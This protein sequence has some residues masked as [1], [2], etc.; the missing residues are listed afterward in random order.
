[1]S[2]EIRRS[3]RAPAARAMVRIDLATRPSLPMTRPRSPS[4]TLISRI[5]SSPSSNSSTS[6][7]SG[8]STIARTRYSTRSVAGEAMLS[9]ARTLGAGDADALG[10]K[11]AGDRG[12]RLSAMVDPVLRALLVKDDGR[13]LGLRVV[14][15]DRLDRAAV[16]R[17][18]L[19]GYD[20]APDG[21]LARTHPSQ[22]DS[23]GHKAALR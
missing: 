19:V 14:V 9:S 18:S 10:P 8:S 2:T 17:R 12:A 16:A 5:S 3:S 11:Q 4:A 7:A 21:V 6:T 23:D 22:S 13:R 15:A 20:N 1:M